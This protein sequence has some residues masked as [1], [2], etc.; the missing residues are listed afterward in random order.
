[1]V[2]PS[3]SLVFR[4][5]SVCSVSESFTL[6]FRGHTN[7]GYN[8]YGYGENAYGKNEIVGTVTQTGKMEIFKVT[9]A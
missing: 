7:H 4:G 9:A 5:G 3:V 8:V 2:W 1:M 6:T